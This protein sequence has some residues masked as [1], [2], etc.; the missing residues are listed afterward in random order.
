M[1]GFRRTERGH[2]ILLQG[3]LGQVA[4]GSLVPANVREAFRRAEEERPGPVHTLSNTSEL[5]VVFS[6]TEAIYDVL[7][8]FCFFCVHCGP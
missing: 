2:D 5:V 1:F 8:P 4:D 3:V 7:L 6:S